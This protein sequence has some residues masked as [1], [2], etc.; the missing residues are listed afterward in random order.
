MTAIDN[1][2]TLLCV[3]TLVTYSGYFGLHFPGR[4]NGRNGSITRPPRSPDITAINLFV[5]GFGTSSIV[6]YL[7]AL[8]IKI[9]DAVQT[10]PLLYWLVYRRQKWPWWPERHKKMYEQNLSDLKHNFQDKCSMSQGFRFESFVMV[11]GV[12]EYSLLKWLLL[13]FHVQLK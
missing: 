13:N 9:M 4:W 2:P 3:P 11:S 7:L 5:W 8:H 1:F 10:F 6:Q 12:L